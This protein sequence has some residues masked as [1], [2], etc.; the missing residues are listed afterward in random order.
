M[1][2]HGDVDRN[3]MGSFIDFCY[4][5]FLHSVKL[6]DLWNCTYEAHVVF[7]FSNAAGIGAS[8]IKALQ[9][10]LSDS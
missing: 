3:S 1:Q 5:V 7:L 10:L 2:K 9:W 4:A 6:Y 8:V